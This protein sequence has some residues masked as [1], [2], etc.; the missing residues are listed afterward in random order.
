MVKLKRDSKGRFT[1]EYTLNES[2]FTEPN[3]ENSYWAG[4]LAADGTLEKNR[5]RL[6]LKC[7]DSGQLELFRIMTASQAP[8]KT[9]DRPVATFSPVTRFSISSRQWIKDFRENFSLTERK[10]HTL[11]PPSLLEAS[12]IKAFLIGLIDGD[13][14]I[15]LTSDKRIRF[16]LQGNFDL[17]VWLKDFIDKTYPSSDGYSVN[18]NKGHGRV[19]YLEYS[20]KRAHRILLDLKKLALPSLDRKWKIVDSY[21][22]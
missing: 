22:R 4:F 3:Q 13:G 2:Y 11:Q 7:G 16:S 15:S 8:V 12:Y 6:S 1:K 19:H 5:V 18:V 9:Y 14:N 21:K 20:G 17:L 10:T